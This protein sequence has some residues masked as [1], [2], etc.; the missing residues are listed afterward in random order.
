MLLETRM[1]LIE[2]W[3]GTRQGM[4]PPR[5]SRSPGRPKHR[6]SGAAGACPKCVLFR[7]GALDKFA[8]SEVQ[9]GRLVLTRV[10]AR[11]SRRRGLHRRKGIN[12]LEPRGRSA[13][14]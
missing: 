3:R 4:A 6:Q 7:T 14:V 2:Q 10:L 8:N 1:T 12:R 11:R 9:P 13:H 5:L